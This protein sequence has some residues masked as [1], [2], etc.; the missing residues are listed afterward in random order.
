[1]R[2]LVTGSQ[3]F[4]GRHLVDWAKRQGAHV[5]GCIRPGRPAPTDSDVEWVEWDVQNGA[6]F[7]DL[8]RSRRP[9]R[10]FHL[11]AIASVAAAERDRTQ[12]LA[13]N[14]GGVL[15]I[16]E[17]LS[18]Q[19]SS[20][21]LVLASSCEVYG[22]GQP[23]RRLNELSPQRPVTFYGVSKWMAEETVRL[24]ARRSVD[25]VILRPFNH[26]GPGQAPAFVSSSFARQIVAME[27]GIQ[28]LELKTGN[29]EVIRDFSDVRDVVRAYWLAAD[30]AETGQ[31]YNVA[32]GSPTSIQGMLELLLEQTEVEVAVVR[33]P[34][35]QR[36]NDNPYLVGDAS[37]LGQEV[38]W[39]PE[40]A[41]RQTVRDLLDEWRERSDEDL[42]SQ[43]DSLSKVR[44]SS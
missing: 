44:P 12:T 14:T 10:I 8:L 20:A 24:F 11:A 23:G 15:A 5:V 13:V 19:D 7:A 38:G 25:G 34:A 6:A 41:L 37:R 4:A 22:P 3:G 9:D 29:L 21:R 17:A 26:I 36:K 35:L 1:M 40:I 27:R 2:V 33:D 32:S 30:S 28:P 39:R 16:V 18:D 31:T 43:P 42:V